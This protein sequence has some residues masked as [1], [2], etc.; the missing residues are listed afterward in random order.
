[1]HSVSLIYS[2]FACREMEKEMS[3]LSKVWLWVL[4]ML[5]T[6]VIIGDAP[7]AE[8]NEDRWMK[9]SVGCIWY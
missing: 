3:T 9:V 8:F 6:L 1:M 2:L 4:T 7:T 5:S